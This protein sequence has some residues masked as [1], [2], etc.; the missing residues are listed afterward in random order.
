MEADFVGAPVGMMD[1]LASVYGED[2]YV[3]LIDCQRAAREFRV[4]A[5][6]GASPADLDRLADPLLA[7]RARHVVC[8]DDRVLARRLAASG[9]RPA[10]PGTSCGLARLYA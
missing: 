8:E 10:R 5:L 4:A 2:L 9:G 1:Q 3:L 7:A 6:G